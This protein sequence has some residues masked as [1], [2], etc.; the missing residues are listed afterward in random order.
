MFRGNQEDLEAKLLFLNSKLQQVV[1]PGENKELDERLSQ[2]IEQNKTWNKDFI[3]SSPFRNP[4]TVENFLLE[5]KID[6]NGSN[7]PNK[8]KLVEFFENIQ[9]SQNTVLMKKQKEQEML[10]QSME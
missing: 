4:A 2:M 6:E 3:L 8:L 7:N 5:Q 9:A 10:R 1:Q